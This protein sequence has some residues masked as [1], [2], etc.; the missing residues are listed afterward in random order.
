MSEN[1]EPTVWCDGLVHIYR[2]RELE[3]VALQGLN[4]EVDEGEVVGMIG[5]SGSGK[6]TLMNILAGVVPPTAGTAVVAGFDLGR[7][8]EGGRELYRRQ[9]VGYVVQHAQANL[10]PGLTARENV[11]TT[12]RGRRHSA[13]VDR[14]DYL[15]EAFGI[16]HAAGKKPGE[17]SGGEAQRVALA[18]ALANGPRLLLADEPT[19]ELDSSGAERLLTELREALRRERTS[20]IIVTH[21]PDVELHTDRVVQIRDGRTSTEHRWVA[22]EKYELVIIDRAGRLQVP[23]TYVEQ[24][25]LKGRVRME[26]R[27][28]ELV[29]RPAEGLMP[30]VVDDA[31]EGDRSSE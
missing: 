27:G 14:A 2:A 29:I 19:S 8:D 5:R 31:A 12:M 22:H 9:V 4:L 7:L 18:S 13:A 26:V 30:K 25:K 24:L 21:D 6:T 10:V 1:A 16:L 17:L 3:V 15:L 28:D 11:V 20:A 23:H